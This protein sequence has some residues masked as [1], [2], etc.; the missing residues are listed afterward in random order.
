MPCHP[1]RAREL[2]R[3]GRAAVYR[4]FPFTIIIKDR[5][6]G[7]TQPTVLKFDPGSK[8]T[9]IAVVADFQRGKR[10]IFAAELEH[11][12]EQIK[13]ALEKRRNIRRSR[14]SRK[15]RYRKA[16]FE[17]RR[18]PKGWLA[19][20]LQS[21]VDNIESWTRKFRALIPVSSLSVE[22]VRF[23][24]HKL[25]N[26][27][28]QGVEYQQGTL[29]GYQVRE[30][31]LEKWGRKCAYCGKQNVPLQVE[32][33]T[34]K[35]RGG[36]NRV[37]NLTLACEM[38]NQKKGSKTAGGFG[39]PGLCK[40]ADRPLRAVAVVN[41]TRPA[42]LEVL[43]STGLSVET[44]S[45]GQTK[46]NRSQQ[47]YAKEH[48]IDAMCVGDSGRHVF[49]EKCHEVLEIKAMGRG[50]RQ[51]CRVDRF[52]FPR[53]GAKKKEKRV[54]GFQTGDIVKA[55]V[56]KGKKKGTYVGRVAVRS[57][58]NFNIKEGKKTTQGIAAKYCK[59]VQK[60][61]GYNYNNRMGVSSP[62]LRRGSPR[63]GKME[64]FDR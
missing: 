39:F 9:G 47:G 1:A 5:E 23:D 18:K 8:K 32:H 57:S 28:V 20:S 36:S 7:A 62:L 25:V 56:T 30:Y 24:T 61:D 2:L 14:R 48:W 11:R 37:D 59:M 49:V 53:T 31:L 63:L 13:K 51:M 12:G 45:G 6:G 41:S 64:A 33:M 26:P 34:P 35:S 29:F 17:N 4:R 44:G 16:R 19:P 10:C 46:F 50:T 3:K 43:K 55:I 60:I 54:D 58:G 22:N 38:C 15:T 42:I 40:K 21:R 27:E 52:G